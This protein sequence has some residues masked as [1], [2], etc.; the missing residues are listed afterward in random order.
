MRYIYI[1]M[2]WNITQPLKKQNNATC[3]SMDG[4]RDYHTKWSQSERE[5]Q[6]LY[7]IACMWNLKY[8]TNE[9][10]YE[11]GTDSQT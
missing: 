2:Q 5:T 3:S 1:Y 8:Y 4:P 6:I 10:I 11:T 7:D 9:F